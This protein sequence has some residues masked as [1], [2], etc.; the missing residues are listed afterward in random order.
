MNETHATGITVTFT[1]IFNN[2]FLFVQR[3]LDDPIL[4][5]YWCFPGGRV[6]VGETLAGALVRE[7]QEETALTPTGRAFFVD[8]YVLGD[9]VGAHFAVEVTDDAVTLAELENHTWV[10]S[11]KELAGFSP[12]IDGI[13]THLHYIQQHLLD[14]GDH[15]SLVWQPLEQFD[16]V[17]KRFRN[18]DNVVI[19]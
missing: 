5:G 16:L 18:I 19:V 6:H 9:R 12:R 15:D 10:S 17:S 8:S 4:A 11:V 1:P 14:A 7:L 3:K 2:K 13:D